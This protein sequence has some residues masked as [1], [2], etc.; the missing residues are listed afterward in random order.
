MLTTIP[1][2]AVDCVIIGGSYAGLSAALVL[3]R[4][5]RN[6]IVID[7]GLPCNRFAPHS[8]NFLTHDGSPP[9]EIAELG[10][11]QIQAKYKSVHFVNDRVESATLSSSSSLFELTT[12]N[13]DTIEARKIIF[14]S[15]VKDI[16]PDIPGFAECWGKTIIHCPY[17]HGFEFQ[18]QPTGLFMNANVAAHMAPIVRNLTPDVTLFCSDTSGFSEEQLNLIQANQIPIITS[19]ITEFQHDNG[20][21]IGVVVEDGREIALKTLYAHIPFELNCK[22]MMESLG[23]TFTDH[24]FISINDMQ[25]S[26]SS[27]VPGIFACG[28]A[29]TMFRSVANAVRG[30]NIAGAVAN[31]EL[32]AADFTATANGASN[33]GATTAATAG[34]P[35]QQ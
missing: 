19:P 33:T 20:Q 9:S 16:F 3:G 11:Q 4:S 30:G 34:T 15:G 23:C 31:M 8:Q 1:T 22:A 21:L 6:T 17:C 27:T 14:A 2:A 26:T 10:R 29:T 35:S 12:L 7:E 28:D 5:L 25:K 18:S 13:G 32:C 24:G